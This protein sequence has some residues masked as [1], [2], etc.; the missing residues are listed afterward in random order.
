MTFSLLY[1]NWQNQL[2]ATWQ[3]PLN[4]VAICDYAI[5]LHRGMRRKATSCHVIYIGYYWITN[6]HYSV[7]GHLFNMFLHYL[8]FICCGF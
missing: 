5:H 2:S 6:F 8:I 7:D 4:I 3:L 1:S